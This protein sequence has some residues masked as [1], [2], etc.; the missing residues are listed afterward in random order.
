[1]TTQPK[2]MQE[3]WQDSY[4]AS[5]NESYLEDLYDKYLLNP[6]DISSEWR[7]YFD[8]LLQ[9]APGAMPDFSHEAIREQLVQLAKQSVRST[10]H[11]MDSY[12]D[13]QQERII[14][15]ISSYRRFG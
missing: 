7:D 4:L 14:E 1:M 11:S 8:N 13:Q 2:T 15:L 6:Q 5:G 12:Q 3:L 10:A 9:K